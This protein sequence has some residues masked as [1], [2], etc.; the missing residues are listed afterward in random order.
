MGTTVKTCE[1]V[2][3]MASWLRLLKIRVRLLC[4]SEDSL[5]RPCGD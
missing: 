1:K 2:D 5:R 3:M 4:Y